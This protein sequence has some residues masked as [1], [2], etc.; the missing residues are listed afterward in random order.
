MILERQE[1]L[2]PKDDQKYSMYDNQMRKPELSYLPSW[3]LVEFNRLKSKTLISEK[4]YFRSGEENK[5]AGKN[6]SRKASQL[7]LCEFLIL[8]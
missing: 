6:Y 1:N 8:I 4:N 3:I 5:N 2:P 7:H